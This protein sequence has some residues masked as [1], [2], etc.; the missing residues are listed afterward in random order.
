MSTYGCA[1][2]R[3]SGT[4]RRTECAPARYDL[5]APGGRAKDRRIK[6]LPGEGALLAADRATALRSV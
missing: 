1:C 5:C 2:G 3:R 4:G 6:A